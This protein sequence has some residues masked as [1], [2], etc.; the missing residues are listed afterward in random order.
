M[1]KFLHDLEIEQYREQFCNRCEHGPRCVIIDA[2][3]VYR[4]G[5][6]AIDAMLDVLIPRMASSMV[7]GECAMY[8]ENVGRPESKRVGDL[9]LDFGTKEVRVSGRE[10]FLSPVEF[11]LMHY[12]VARA[13]QTC[14]WQEL[15]RNVWNFSTIGV[16]HNKDRTLPRVHIRNIR[17]KIEED[18]SNP[19]ILLTVRRYGYMIAKEKE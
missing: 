6:S 8:I 2:H 3:S 19:K 15:L 5:N 7:N 18:P 17:L 10:V 12:L 16:L 11:Q 14:T 4:Y 13:G 9:F 1:G